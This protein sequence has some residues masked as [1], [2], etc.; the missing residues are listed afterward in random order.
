MDSSCSQ[1]NGKDIREV[2]R[3]DENSG[4][5]STV[6]TNSP[7][8]F[9]VIEKSFGYKNDEDILTLDDN[10]SSKS[11]N[12]TDWNDVTINSI[13]KSVCSRM[14]REISPDNDHIKELDL[15]YR[16]F[17]LSLLEYSE[18][19]VKINILLMFTNGTLYICNLISF[20][21]VRIYFFSI[22]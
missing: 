8:N 20:T 12:E 3:Q 22:Q 19:V 14:E 15:K 1:R 10:I 21:I 18:E 13:E 17:V 7:E 9:V 2:Q 11:L 5:N 6:G 16:Y 4:K